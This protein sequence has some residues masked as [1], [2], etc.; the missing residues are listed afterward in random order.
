MGKFV[1]QTGKIRAELHKETKKGQ[2]VKW[3]QAFQ[4]CLGDTYDYE[5]LSNRV[6]AALEAGAFYELNDNTKEETQVTESVCGIGV[7][8][9]STQG[10]ARVDS[11]V[12]VSFNST[13]GA[14]PT[15]AEKTSGKSVEAWKADFG[16]VIKELFTSEKQTILG[17]SV[18][19]IF[20]DLPVVMACVCVASCT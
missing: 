19:I 10:Y 3:N 18:C 17:E 4:T 6:E 2:L 12:N 15:A 13:C 7:G 5:L 1:R 8:S 9:S 14:K 11:R 20:M 16:G